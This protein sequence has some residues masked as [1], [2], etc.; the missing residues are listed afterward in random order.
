MTSKARKKARRLHQGGSAVL[1]AVG[2]AVLGGA[3]RQVDN[4]ITLMDKMGQKTVLHLNNE[5]GAAGNRRITIYCPY[6]LV[7]LTQCALLLIVPHQDKS[8]KW[9]AAMCTSF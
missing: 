1:Q 5:V 3:R 6:W 7:N 8:L 9:H 2:S 4:F